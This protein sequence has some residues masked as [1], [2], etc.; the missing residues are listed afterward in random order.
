MTSGNLTETMNLVTVVIRQN[1]NVAVNQQHDRF[2]REQ[3]NSSPSS[4]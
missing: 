2:V 3:R 4:V 1:L